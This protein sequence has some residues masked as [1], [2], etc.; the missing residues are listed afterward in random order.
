MRRSDFVKVIALLCSFFRCCSFTRDVVN[1]RIF[2]VEN[3][4]IIR[5]YTM[6]DGIELDKISKGQ[7][8]V[9]YRKCL[10]YTAMN[11]P[12]DKNFLKFSLSLRLVYP[13][14]GYTEDIFD[15]YSFMA[16]TSYVTELT[17][18][19]TN[20][21][22]VSTKYFHNHK[23]LSSCEFGKDWLHQWPVGDGL[24]GA[25]VGGSISM[26]VIPL[27]I[28]DLFAFNRQDVNNNIEA[29]INENKRKN[30]TEFFQKGDIDLIIDF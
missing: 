9:G 10:N 16:S 8:I 11:D 2:L 17:D 7:I 13:L 15:E 24:K 22:R 19:K 29:E 6:G 14:D 26:E 12:N 21:C 23:M 25:L 4:L 30:L 18:V 5:R 20:I 3:D 28:A 1:A 27:S